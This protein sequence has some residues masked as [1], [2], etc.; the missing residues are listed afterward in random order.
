M[1]NQMHKQNIVSIVNLLKI[2][3][4]HSF[5]ENYEDGFFVGQGEVGDEKVLVKIFSKQIKGKATGLSKEGKV[6]ELLHRNGLAVPLV[7]DFGESQNYVWLI[8]KFYE[9]EAL[10]N[11]QNGAPFYGYDNLKQNLLDNPEKIITDLGENLKKLRIIKDNSVYSNRYKKELEAYPLSD[12]EEGLEVNLSKQISFYN[13]IKS[14]FLNEF[15]ACASLGDLVPANIIVLE[16]QEI[17]ISDFEWFSFDN[18][19]MD[20]AFLWLFLWQKPD[21][22]DYLIDSLSMSKKEEDFFRASIIRQIIGWYHFTYN[23]KLEFNE[24]RE[25][26]KEFYKEHIWTRYLIAAGQSYDELLKVKV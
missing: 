6:G 15:N 5:K 24:K 3:N 20:C 18:K 19:M 22:Q 25:F 14:E 1:V 17:M 26:R 21:W 2:E 12:I 10:A 9:G 7:L 8:R 11:F 23:K 16:N 4:T 13:Q